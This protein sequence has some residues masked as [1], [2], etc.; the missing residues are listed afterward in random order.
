MINGEAR[1]AMAD[2]ITT[3]ATERLLRR[4]AVL[5]TD[6]MASVS[7]VVSLQLGL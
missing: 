1:K 6:D 5:S 2:Q 7:R 4:L 3:A